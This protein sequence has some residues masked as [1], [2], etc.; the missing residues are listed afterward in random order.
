MGRFCSNISEIREWSSKRQ[1]ACLHKFEAWNQTW[2]KILLFSIISAM[3]TIWLLKTFVLFTYLLLP[4]ASSYVSFCQMNSGVLGGGTCP[5]SAADRTFSSIIPLITDGNYPSLYILPY[6]N[7]NNDIECASMCY[8]NLQCAYAEY[9]AIRKNIT[10][11]IYI[12]I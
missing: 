9:Y 2:H 4:N 1:L 7:V 3:T 8:T 5:S 6:P 12:Y 11:Y 10:Q